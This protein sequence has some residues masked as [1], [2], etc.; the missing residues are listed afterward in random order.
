MQALSKGAIAIVL[1]DN[2]SIPDEIFTHDKAAK[3]LVRDS[4]VVLAE[5]SN[6]FIKN[7]RKN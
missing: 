2:N 4:R 6:I 1:E 3:I 5:I 7:H